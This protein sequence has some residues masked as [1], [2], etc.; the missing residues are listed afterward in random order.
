[1]NLV[2][3]S[4]RPSEIPLLFLTAVVTHLFISLS[5]TVM[6]YGLGHRRLGGL[7]FRNHLHYHQVHYLKDH[8]VSPVHIKKDR[9]NTPFF[10]IPV[11]FIIASSYF[12]FPLSVFTIPIIPA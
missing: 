9:N 2:W 7:F 8:L 1:M 5:Q 6:H 12:I 10:L 4:E 3:W 11:A